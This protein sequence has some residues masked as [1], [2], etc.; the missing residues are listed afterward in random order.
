MTQDDS[1][2]KSNY[3]HAKTCKALE[4]GFISVTSYSRQAFQSTSTIVANLFFV[5]SS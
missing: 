1:V 5:A 4:N 2:T 3:R